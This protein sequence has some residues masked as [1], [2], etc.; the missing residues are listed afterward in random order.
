MRL[1]ALAVIGVLAA[2]GLAAPGMIQA[3]EGPSRTFGPSDLFGLQQA[4]EAGR[5]YQRMARSLR[6]TLA[7]KAKL[8]RD[9]DAAVRE[10]AL[11]VAKSRSTVSIL[12]SDIAQAIRFVAEPLEQEKLL[13]ALEREVEAEVLL[14]GFEDAPHETLVERVCARLPLDDDRISAVTRTAIFETAELWPQ[15]V[16]PP[17]G[18]PVRPPRPPRRESG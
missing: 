2:G 6:Q 13:E 16:R 7:I 4:S 14:P 9:R 5:T 3:Q 1:A 15:T 11:R 10:Q 12:K 8:K 17:P 18:M